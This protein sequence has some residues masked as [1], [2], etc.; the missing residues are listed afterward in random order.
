M[1]KAA[2]VIVW[3]EAPMMNKHVFEAVDRTLRD[4]MAPVHPGLANK[5]F[6][7]K[8][9]VMGGDFRQILPVVTKA[10]KAEIVAATL[11]QS[12]IIW[13]H[14]HVIKL[15]TNMRVQR[16]LASD[17]PNA[18]ADAL[19]LGAFAAY[20]KRIGDGT[21]PVRSLSQA[22]QKLGRQPLPLTDQ[23]VA[24]AGGA[25]IWGGLHPDTSPHVLLRHH[26]RGP[27]Q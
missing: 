20:I 9:V 18:Q 16:M 27:H 5:P 1:I 8:V 11:N 22:W 2:A 10:R 26:R 19:C 7:G 12:T 17:G 6:G 4:I 25:R 3:D 13:P 24:C 14:V 23:S 15:H 21:E